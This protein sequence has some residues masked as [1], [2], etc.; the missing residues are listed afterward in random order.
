MYLFWL[1][2]GRKVLY[3][4]ILSRWKR[5][6]RHKKFG[7][8]FLLWSVM[9][10][11]VLANSARSFCYKRWGRFFHFLWRLMYFLTTTLLSHEVQHMT[12]FFFL[13]EWSQINNVINV[14]FMWSLLNQL[15][16]VMGFSVDSRIL[17]KVTLGICFA[18][19]FVE[20]RFT[21]FHIFNY[22]M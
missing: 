6:L 22:L 20:R 11:P 3:S 17:F 4:Y 14:K 16:K 18:L 21:S 2:N 8:I 9:H 12:S 7:S 15:T 19:K 10:L 1:W 5:G 13:Q